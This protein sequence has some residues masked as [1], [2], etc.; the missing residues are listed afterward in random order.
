[1]DLAQ[2]IGNALA[3]GLGPIVENAVSRIVNGVE[4]TI[5]EEKSD[6]LA[7]VSGKEIEVTIKIP[8]LTK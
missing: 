8:D 6:L 3:Q 1:M 5:K 7:K 4:K 2:A